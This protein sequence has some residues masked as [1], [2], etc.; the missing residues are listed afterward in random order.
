MSRGAPRYC[1]YQYRYHHEY[2]H[3]HYGYQYQYYYHHQYHYHYDYHCQ[4]YHYLY[5]YHDHHHSGTTTTTT[6]TTRSKYVHSEVSD[7]GGCLAHIVARSH[8]KRSCLMRREEGVGNASI[9]DFRTLTCMG[10]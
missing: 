7:T 9:T 4:H 8:P 5:N 10:N 6:I 1:H 2:H 3:C